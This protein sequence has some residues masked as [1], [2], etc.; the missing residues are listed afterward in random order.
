MDYISYISEYVVEGNMFIL[1]DAVLFLHRVLNYS[2]GFLKDPSKPTDSLPPLEQLVPLDPSGIYIL[3][4]SITVQDVNP[5][6]LKAAAHRL[7][8]VKDHLKSV[9]KLEPGDRLALD[10][11]VK[12]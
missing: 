5:D 9:A 7:T 12:S 8:R 2:P 6:M 10:T 3:Q 4:A 1:D 11:R